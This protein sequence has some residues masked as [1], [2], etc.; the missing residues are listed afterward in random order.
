MTKQYNIILEQK[1]NSFS[2]N[3]DYFRLPV[4]KASVDLIKQFWNSTQKSPM[5]AKLGLLKDTEQEMIQMIY[6]IYKS[7]ICV[8]KID[9]L[10]KTLLLA[11]HIQLELRIYFDL[12]FLSK[13]GFTIVSSKSEDV[14][15]QLTG[16]LKSYNH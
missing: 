14:V 9:T 10:T 15:R 1:K 11:K 13:N 7:A 8:D 2:K 16:W 6:N 5:T 12:G 4:Y 3:K